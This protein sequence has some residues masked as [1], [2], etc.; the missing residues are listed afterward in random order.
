METRVAIV[1]LI[2]ALIPLSIAYPSTVPPTPTVCRS[3][4]PGHGPGPQ[5]SAAPCLVSSSLDAVKNG[6]QVEGK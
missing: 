1:L 4:T 2:G 3:M 5:K 6:Q